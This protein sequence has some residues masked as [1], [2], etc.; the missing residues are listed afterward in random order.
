MKWYKEKKTPLEY[1][2]VIQND[3]GD[4]SIRTLSTDSQP[5][6][7]KLEKDL[8]LQWILTPFLIKEDVQY[9]FIGETKDYAIGNVASFFETAKGV[10]INGEL[11]EIRVSDL[12]NDIFTILQNK[13][14]DFNPVVK[15]IYMRDEISL[16]RGALNVKDYEII[17]PAFR[18]MN[19]EKDSEID[20]SL[21]DFLVKNSSNNDQSIIIFPY[22]WLF[23]DELL[24]SPVLNYFSNFSTGII[25]TV[26]INT[27]HVRAIE[28]VK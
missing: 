5:D 11:I 12:K 26:N 21:W 18:E 6:I 2:G 3:S 22:N 17:M 4:F 23:S 16:S 27:Q 1:D 24:E 10:Y 7:T 13:A 8:V 25:L 9:H 14:S 19:T 20:G 15:D 28:L